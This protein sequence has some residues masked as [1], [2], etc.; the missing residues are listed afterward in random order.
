MSQ[1]LRAPEPV[2]SWYWEYD[3]KDGPVDL[4]I[5]LATAQ[6]MINVLS[7]FGL[8]KHGGLDYDWH[9][10]GRG[11]IGV[12]TGLYLPGPLDDPS[13][14]DRIRATQPIGYPDAEL[15]NI[16]VIGTGTWLDADGME[17]RELRLVDLEVKPDP[18]GQF[19]ELFVHHDIWMPCGFDGKPHPAIHRRN[20]PRLELALEKLS[21]TLGARP[22]PGTSTFFGEADGFAIRD[23]SRLS[24]DGTGA[25]VT[26]WL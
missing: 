14:P 12:T 16:N 10:R 6:K 13:V 11:Q 18:I 5:A 7:E 3:D 23:D 15:D 17:H 4:T 19:A 1:L 8:L 22:M 2:G 25:D 26:D 20:A 21:Q 9:I 24:T